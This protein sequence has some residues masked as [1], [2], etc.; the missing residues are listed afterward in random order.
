MHSLLNMLIA[1]VCLGLVTTA[2]AGDSPKANGNSTCVDVAVNG[3]P[4]LAYDC[5]NQQ[6]AAGAVARTP[7]APTTTL[8]PV[9]SLPS[10][11]QVGQF[12]FSS[13]SNRMGANL[14]KSVLPQRP[15]PPAVPTHVTIPSVPGH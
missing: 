11:Q 14:G 1:T 12:N 5:L 7:V 15:P 2:W 4:V 6:L 10:N 13:F 8:D 9:A 3:H